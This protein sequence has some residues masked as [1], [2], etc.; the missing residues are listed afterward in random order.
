[1]GHD[2][3]QEDSEY[4]RTLQECFAERGL[5]ALRKMVT[6]SHLPLMFERSLRLQ[7]GTV[8]DRRAL[9][10]LPVAALGSDGLYEVLQICRVMSS[11]ESHQNAIQRF[12]HR[13]EFVHFGFECSGR[14]LIGK[15]Y[16]EL[17]EPTSLDDQPTRQLIFLGFKWSA[18]DDSVAVVSRYRSLPCT[19]WQQIR[20]AMLCHL[21]ADLRPSVAD[22]LHCLASPADGRNSSTSELRLLAV[23]DEG[24]DRV[25]HDLN[26]YSLNCPAAGVADCLQA[27]G[28]QLHVDTT[29]LD[30]WNCRYATATI[31]HLSTGLNRREQP[32]LTLYHTADVNRL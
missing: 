11:P 10:S 20:E 7:P 9:F 24:S 26:V 14:A 31:G 25:S 27:I 28:R 1:M 32:F 17:A 29:A 16:L 30:A 8:E 23:T 4:R 2:R 19:G 21:P 6:R 3:R 12:F 15:C 22:L 5:N 18:T 13:A